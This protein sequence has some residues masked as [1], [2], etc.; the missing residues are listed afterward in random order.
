[1]RWR[2]G[3]DRFGLITR[4]LHWAMGLGIIGMLGFGT[5]LSRMQPS[6]GNIWLYGLHKS[7]G[8]CLLALVLAR[9]AWHRISP[10]PASLT[11]GIAPWQVA[12]G[13]WA[14]RLLYALMLAV[15]LAGWIGS[16]ATGIDVQVFGLTL[17]NPFPVSEAWDKGGF[18]AHAVLTKLLMA[19]VALHVAGALHRALWHRDGTLR[20]MLR[21]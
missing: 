6:L 14:H 16:A 1:M 17:P 11:E 12:A 18:L 5:V 2:N 3:P 7:V 9:L 8:L 15:P 10:P 21:A 20:R 4:M 19:V 13:R